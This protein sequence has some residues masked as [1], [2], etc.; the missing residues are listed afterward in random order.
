MGKACIL[1]LSKVATSLNGMVAFG[2]MDG[3]EAYSESSCCLSS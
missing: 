3:D 1:A 2:M